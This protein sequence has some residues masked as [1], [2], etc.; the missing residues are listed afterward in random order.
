M[1]GFNICY[2]DLIETIGIIYI[3]Q[4]SANSLNVNKKNKIY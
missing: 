1:S 2:I 4:Y 3:Y